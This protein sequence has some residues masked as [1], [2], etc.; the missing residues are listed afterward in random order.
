MR[1]TGL[2]TDIASRPIPTPIP[3]RV[4]CSSCRLLITLV[5]YLRFVL[6][7]ALTSRPFQLGAAA[8]LA[9]LGINEAG[10]FDR[11]DGQHPIT[12]WIKSQHPT[13]EQL[14][15]SRLLALHRAAKISS[16][17][18]T[19]STARRPGYQRVK[20]TTYVFCIL[21]YILLS[22]PR[23][24]GWFRQCVY[25]WKSVQRPS[26]LDPSGPQY[27]NYHRSYRERT[28]CPKPSVVPCRSFPNQLQHLNISN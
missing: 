16:H 19:T 28:L 11:K 2:D 14:L 10:F 27:K 5:A 4:S 22:F 8:I 20:N 12:K 18:R 15:R 17:N 25:K 24:N 21:I 13:D 23:S 3:Q 1:R 6:S 7:K 26:R 9:V